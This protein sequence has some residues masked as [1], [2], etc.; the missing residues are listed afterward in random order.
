MFL[1]QRLLVFYAFRHF[2][3]LPDRV[4]EHFISKQPRHL[5]TTMAT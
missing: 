5:P 1:N 3:G 4:S 2:C